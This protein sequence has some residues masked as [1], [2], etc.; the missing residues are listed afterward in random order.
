MT[1]DEKYL[2]LLAIFHYVVGG[3]TAMVACFPLIHVAVGVAMILGELD[4]PH[5]APA[6][7]GW[8][9]IIFPGMLILCGWAMAIAIIVAG[10]KLKSRTSHTYCV[11]VGAIECM[12]MPFGTVLGVLTIILLM[13]DSVKQ[14]F[15]RQQAGRRPPESA[16]T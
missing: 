11:V 1:E 13:K 3:L 9:F 2:D 12:F 16:H 7:I 8:I 6:G 15:V 10:T 14:M 5:P 4:G